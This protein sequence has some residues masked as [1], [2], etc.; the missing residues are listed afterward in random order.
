MT[1]ASPHISQ[2]APAS[3]QSA[4][5]AAVAAEMSALRSLPTD[6]QRYLALRALQRLAQ[7]WLAG[8]DP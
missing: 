6:L 2:Q 7:L 3:P 1:V 8:P 5:L 4:K